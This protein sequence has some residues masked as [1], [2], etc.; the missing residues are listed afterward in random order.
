MPNK[1]DSVYDRLMAMMDNVNSG[2]ISCDQADR[3]AAGADKIARLL[4]VETQMIDM[5]WANHKDATPSQLAGSVIDANSTDKSSPM[6]LT[7]RTK[8]LKDRS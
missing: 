1:L 6:R 5:A 2:A 3:I 8:L 4:V 7:D